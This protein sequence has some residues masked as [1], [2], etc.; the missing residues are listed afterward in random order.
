MPVKRA[1]N[2]GSVSGFPQKKYA[3]IGADLPFNMSQ[4]LVA[5]LGNQ[6]SITLYGIAIQVA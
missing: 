6:C 4:H 5:L 1:G 3:F 2:S